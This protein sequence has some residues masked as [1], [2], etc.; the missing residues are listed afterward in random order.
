M[1]KNLSGMQL[2]DLS[3]YNPAKSS[4]VSFPLRNIMEKSVA[5]KERV[6]LFLN[7]KGFSTVTRCSQC[8]RALVCPRCNVNLTYLYS[9]KK[10]VCR[11][12]R[13]T[14]EVPKICPQCKSSYL[15]SLGTGIEKLE[16]EIARIFPTVRVA[17]FD[18]ESAA[19]PKGVDI[20]IATQAVLKVLDGFKADVIAILEFDAQL[21]RVDFRSSEKAFAS[22]IALRC[23]AKKKLV[24]QTHQTNN[25]II[26]AA[27]SMNFDYFYEEEMKLREELQLPPF[28]HLIAI[29]L[30]G[31]EEDAVFAE[32]QRLYE[33]LGK[34]SPLYE[35]SDPQPD[36]LAKL[37]D[38]YRF[39]I[40]VKTASVV[41][42]LAQVK[43]VLKDLRRKKNIIITVNVDP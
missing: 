2:I 20:L 17:R 27:A 22:L 38:Q 8:G 26:Q 4:V 13:Y 5:Q 21:N 31:R 15:R 29:G 1:P 39:T 41:E 19:L 33:K 16:S 11:M 6:L 7:R 12:C 25:Y 18:K 10:M 32:A 30:R 37:R 40:M 3:N 9:K 23:A 34:D 36:L 43:T 35:V 42:M 14:T 28:K 24:V